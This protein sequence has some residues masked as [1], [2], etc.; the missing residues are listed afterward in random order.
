MS[1]ELTIPIGF[2]TSGP[3][4]RSCQW[5][6]LQINSSVYLPSNFAKFP[7]NESNFSTATLTL[8]KA[9][10]FMEQRTTRPVRIEHS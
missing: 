4:R 1:Y 6:N 5:F 8:V 10:N 2:Y 3:R 7:F 9:D